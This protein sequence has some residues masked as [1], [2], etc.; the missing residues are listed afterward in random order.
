MAAGPSSFVAGIVTWPAR[1]AYEVLQLPSSL[2]ALRGL[3]QD[4]AATSRLVREAIGQV[5]STMEPL[6]GAVDRVANIDK[7]VGDLHSVFFSVLER[8]P[9]GKRALRGTP[10]E[11]A[12][13]TTAGSASPTD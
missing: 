7:A 1:M 9:G 10:T 13:Q 11:R 3:T 5:A 2:A 8:V 4:L 12:D 6:A